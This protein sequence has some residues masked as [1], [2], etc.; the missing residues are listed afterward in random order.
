MIDNNKQKLFVC[1]RDGYNS[2]DFL[3]IDIILSIEEIQIICEFLSRVEAPCIEVFLQVDS[4]I[5]YEEFSFTIDDLRYVA[6]E[7]QLH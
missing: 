5:E 6:I 7:E 2:I 1:S 4:S 3:N